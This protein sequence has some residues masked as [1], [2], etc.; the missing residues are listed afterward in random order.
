MRYWV[1]PLATCLITAFPASAETAA[2]TIPDAMQHQT[3]APNIDF[4]NLRDPFA[5]YLSRMATAAGHA[6]HQMRLA[7]NRQREK[8]EGFDLSALR[9]V[10]IF[11]MGGERVA[12]VEDSAIKGHIVRRGNYMGQN[13]GKIEKITDDTVF[14]IE[15]VLN[16]AGDMIDR[17]VTLTMKEVNE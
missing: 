10:A 13:S 5:S 17:Q 1:L 15:Q 2:E 6:S 3:A 4:S 11:T 8:L 7:N 12:M 14:L 16:P 9:L